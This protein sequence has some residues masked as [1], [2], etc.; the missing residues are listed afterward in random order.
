MVLFSSLNPTV[1]EILFKNNFINN[2]IIFGL[3]SSLVLQSIS[4]QRSDDQ[5]NEETIGDQEVVIKSEDNHNNGSSDEEMCETSQ[6]IHS[7]EGLFVCSLNDCQ[8]TFELK[9]NYTRHQLVVHPETF[10]HK[11]WIQCSHTIQ[12]TLYGVDRDSPVI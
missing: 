12:I 2:S 7:T 8:N 5:R 4:C 11:P 10:P 3:N 9:Q 6:D 1:N